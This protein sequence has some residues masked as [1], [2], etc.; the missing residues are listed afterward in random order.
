MN[1]CSNPWA[2]SIGQLI[3]RNP[4]SGFTGDASQANEQAE[5]TPMNSRSDGRTWF[6]PFGTS[7][8]VNLHPTCPDFLHINLLEFVVVIISVGAATTWLE[9]ASLSLLSHQDLQIPAIPVCRL[10]KDNE[11]VRSWVHK[12]CARSTIQERSASE[13]VFPI[14]HL[15]GIKVTLWTTY[16]DLMKLICLVH[17]ATNRYTL[18]MPGY[19]HTAISRQL[20]S[21]S[22]SWTAPYFPPNG[23]ANGNSQSHPKA[24]G[25]HCFLCA[26]HFL[27]TLAMNHDDDILL[28]HVSLDR[29]NY[30]MALYAMHL[31]TGSNLRHNT[32]KAST[33]ND[34][35]TYVAKFL[36]RFLDQEN[37]KQIDS[38]NIAPLIKAVN[39]PR[40]NAGKTCPSAET[41]SHQKCG[42]ISTPGL[43]CWLWCVMTGLHVE[44]FLAGFDSA[45]GLRMMRTTHWTSWQWTITASPRHHS[46]LMTIIFKDPVMFIWPMRKPLH[47]KSMRSTMSSSLATCRKMASMGKL[48]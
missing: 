47:A 4:Q 18:P 14:E 29:C 12:V 21:C 24:I 44:E 17:L 19:A 1:D 46:A 5:H 30:Q 15:A 35:L 37:R 3:N 45:N 43:I 9:D 31:A 22:C 11:T 10:V 32:I 8:D 39:L 27:F 7:K 28:E 20:Q 16:L 6:G 36:G 13:F 41:L 2:I 40:S 26:H 48:A 23:R 25:T 42:T 38:F 34:Y 33:I